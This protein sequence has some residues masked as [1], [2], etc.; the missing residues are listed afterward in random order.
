MTWAAASN[1]HWAGAAR[2]AA[3]D[4]KATFLSE[5]RAASL[6]W[7][8]LD[9]PR[10]AVRGRLSLFIEGAIERALDAGAPPPPAPA[11]VV[12]R[13]SVV[14]D[15]LQRAIVS[16][17]SGIAL[18]LSSLEGITG[19]ERAF[20][21]NDSTTLRWWLDATLERPLRIAFDDANRQLGVYM[22]PRTLESLL[23]EAAAHDDEERAEANE[24]AARMD[25][26]SAPFAADS[27]NDEAGPFS[28][29]AGDKGAAV[30]AAAPG[31]GAT[32]D[33]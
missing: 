4:A 5:A 33:V 14:T 29:A 18:W 28:A 6:L 30:I 8:E 23:A 7:V 32:S 20:D 21:S 27:A 16:G 31:A 2:L 11:S 26:G 13:E 19:S 10:P 3:R 17:T 12:D 9:A 15:Q 25:G 22:E 24:D 1:D